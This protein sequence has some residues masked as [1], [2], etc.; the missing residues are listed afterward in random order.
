M[1]QPSRFMR[2]GIETDEV[3]TDVDDSSTDVDEY[4]SHPPKVTSTGSTTEATGASSTV[5]QP[6]AGTWSDINAADEVQSLPR[7]VHR[8]PLSIQSQSYALM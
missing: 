8:A 4:N 2:L 6:S 7:N 3:T 1:L 5:G